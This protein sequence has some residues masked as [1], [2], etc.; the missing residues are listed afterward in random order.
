MFLDSLMIPVTVDQF[1]KFLS[2]YSFP[3][4][5]R[6]QVYEQY[7]NLMATKKR[8]QDKIQ[9]KVEEAYETIKD[10]FAQFEEFNHYK[11]MTEKEV[12]EILNTQGHASR[13]KYIKM[14]S[15]A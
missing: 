15:E 6:L 10:F 4:R 13:G 12:T 5:L 3:Q 7:K 14:I 11:V 9:S 1:D 8:V 2:L